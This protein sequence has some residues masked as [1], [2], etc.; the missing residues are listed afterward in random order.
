MIL[1][2]R[3]LNQQGFT[4]VEL[5]VATAV[6][7]TILVL[8]TIM[9][10]SI[11][12]LYQKGI[13]QSRVQDAARTITDDVSKHLELSSGGRLINAHNGIDGPGTFC[14]GNTRYT[15]VIGK[16]LGNVNNDTTSTH[17]L[18]RDEIDSTPSCPEVNLNVSNPIAP[19]APF[20]KNGVELMPLNSRLIKFEIGG[21]TSP[22]TF[23]LGIAYGDDE[24]LCSPNDSATCT[25]TRD[26][27]DKTTSPPA[28]NDFVNGDLLCKGSAGDQFCST[29]ISET[30]IVQRIGY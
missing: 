28:W 25:G 12:N 17:V 29:A 2:F 4:I 5:L 18:W 19:T 23:K 15:Y 3:R 27:I 11:G 6:F 16:K 1:K 7:S 8:V 24:L 9:M 22:Y 13:N 21:S 10:T 14:I 26:M 30:N 20:G